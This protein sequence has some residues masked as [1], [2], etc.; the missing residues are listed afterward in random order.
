[1]TVIFYR[2][3]LQKEL[4][5]YVEVWNHH[6]IRKSHNVF[7]QSGRPSLMY[8]N[9]AKFE[10]DEWLFQVDPEVI[11]V[12]KTSEYCTYK[13]RLPC[14][15]EMFDFCT[16]EMENRNLAAPTSPE[17]ALNLYSELQPLV[18]QVLS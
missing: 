17:E 16:M 14:S 1:M 15:E 10:A 18:H 8:E 5:D 4:D 9:S 13:G 2:V 6:Y 11:D 12:C 7:L 3:E